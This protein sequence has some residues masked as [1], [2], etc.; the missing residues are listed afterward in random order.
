MIILGYLIPELVLGNPLHLVVLFP[1][2]GELGFYCYVFNNN[3]F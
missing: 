3:L 2:I 1:E